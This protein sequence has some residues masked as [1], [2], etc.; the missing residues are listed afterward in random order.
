MIDNLMTGIV[1]SAGG[2]AL[3]G[4]FCGY[5]CKK[6]LKLF[7]ILAGAFVMGL[8]ALEYY[9]IIKVD[10]NSVQSGAQNATSWTYQHM[11]AIQHHISTSMTHTA[12]GAIGVGFAGGFALGFIRG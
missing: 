7:A 1:G 3:V 5:A 9:R 12:M 6:M 4:G 8:G 10:W 2:S 11:M